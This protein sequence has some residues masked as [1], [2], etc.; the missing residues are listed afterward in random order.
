MGP[1]PDHLRKHYGSQ[2][3]RNLHGA[4]ALC[5][6]REFPRLGGP[7]MINTCAALIEEVVRAH[8]RPLESVAHGQVVWMGVS[9][10][11]PPGRRTAIGTACL[12]PVVLDLSTPA[13]IEARMA[14]LSESQL[15]LRKAVRLCQQA[16]DQGALLSNCDLAELLA[17]GDNRISMALCR[18]EK[19]TERIVPRRAN[20]HDVGSGLTHKRIICLKHLR[21]GKT[22]DVIARETYHSLEAVDHYLGCMSRVRM[23]RDRGLD[24]QQTALAIN[25]SVGLVREYLQIERE[26]RQGGKP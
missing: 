18:H 17:C 14:G 12:V 5:L 10:D 8:Q 6:A 16:H 21:D 2:L 1:N 13:D 4:L 23:C 22:A 3:G 9:R 15:R 7:R 11:N 25:R 19:L 26:I 24:E 20:L